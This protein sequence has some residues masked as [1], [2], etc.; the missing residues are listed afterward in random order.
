MRPPYTDKRPTAVFDTE[1]FQNYW[2]IA[3]RCVDTGRTRLFELYDGQDLD[4]L[5]IARIVRNWR[6]VG[7]NSNNYDI[8]M[9]SLAMGGADNAL[10]KRASDLIILSDMKPWDFRE[11]FDVTIPSFLDHIDL[12]EV[13]PGASTMPSLKLYAGRMHSA[14]MQDL[15]FEPDE[16]VMPEARDVIRSY[17]G[18]D[19][20]V[21]RDLYFELKPQLELRAA[22]SVEYDVDLRSKSDAQMAEAIIKS[23]LEKRAGTRLYKPAIERH[24]FKY[25]APSFVAFQTQQMRDVLTS[26]EAAE[27]FVGFDGIMNMPDVLDKLEVPIGQSVYT[28]GIGGLHSTEKSVFYESC[29]EFTLK[30]SDV[31]SYY[32]YLILGSGLV[33]KHLGNDFLIIYKKIV[34]RRIK[35][36]HEGLKNIAE[37]LKIVVN[38]VFGKLGSPYSIMY[39]PNL[40]VQVTLTGQLCILM[41]IEALELAG[42]P[43]VSANTDGFVSK[44]PKSL[45]DK[46]F[47]IRFDW[48]LQTGLTT[49][50]KA[51][52]GLY[53]R[54]VNNYIAIPFKGDVKL[55][56]A[57]GP[58]GRGQPGA[59]GLKKNPAGEISAKAVIA[60]L[61]DGTPIEQTIEKCTDVRQFLCVRRVKGGA[62]K[63]GE[64]VGKAIRWYYS[65]QET[66]T[67]V[68]RTTGNKV[69]ET[70]GAKPMMDLAD[71]LPEDIDYGWYIREAYGI[72][73]EIG[74][75]RI[76]PRLRGRTGIA[77]ARMPDQKNIHSLN[78]ATGFTLCGQRPKSVRDSWIE[79]KVM[80]EG[81]R[82]CAKCRKDEL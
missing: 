26:I 36:K 47:A 58:A 27:F 68:Y 77:L 39:E 48:E 28:M 5:G 44:V 57:Y 10:L 55:K 78:L 11:R 37:S 13:S 80:P 59:A 34:D 53:S 25:K 56:G 61:Q 19:L 3:F 6:I 23:Q 69:P 71:E 30:D 7:F 72:L 54:D 35:A 24:A 64:Y 50:E 8:S 32:P 12:I 40:M 52:K 74:H 31:S 38:G 76:D 16:W 15:P 63:D 79:Y 82:F 62:E 70:D 45:E 29:D 67:I 75:G 21:T 17:H 9:L 14:K 42:I 51:Y 49:E 41:L 66:G 4:K 60:F 46:F 81:H 1:C 43:V 65:T 18:N 20:D 22:M 33:P 2:S 73:Q